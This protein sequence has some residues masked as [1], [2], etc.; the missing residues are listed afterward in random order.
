MTYK[1]CQHLQSSLRAVVQGRLFDVQ[2]KSLPPWAGSKFFQ[3][4]EIIT[5]R[6]RNT[7]VWQHEVLIETPPYK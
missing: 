6:Y 7:S 1:A 2:A 3:G 5:G 4:A